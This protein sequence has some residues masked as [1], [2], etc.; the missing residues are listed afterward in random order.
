[1]KLDPRQVELEGGPAV[2]ETGSLGGS[3]GDSVY[4]PNDPVAPEII[5]EVNTSAYV[6]NAQSTG[7]NGYG[8]FSPDYEFPNYRPSITKGPSLI[9]RITQWIWSALS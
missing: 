1:M 9:K 2:V 4:K 7:N 8:S 5:R 6:S 3:Y